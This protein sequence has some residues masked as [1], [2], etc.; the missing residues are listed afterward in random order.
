MTK[1]TVSKDVLRRLIRYYG[2][3][4]AIREREIHDLYC[5][6]APHSDYYHESMWPHR[7]SAKEVY[8]FI[9]TNRAEIV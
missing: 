4:L 3:M 5:Q 2:A 6:L 1:D 7:L 8:D 9:A